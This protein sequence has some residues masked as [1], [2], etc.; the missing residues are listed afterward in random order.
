MTLLQLKLARLR[1]LYVCSFPNGQLTHLYQGKP[2][3]THTRLVL[4]DTRA[5]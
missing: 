3:Y 1:V 4:F 2:T 5:N